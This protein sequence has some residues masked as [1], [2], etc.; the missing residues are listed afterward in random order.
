MSDDLQT[1]FAQLF[2]ASIFNG[3]NAKTNNES[4]GTPDLTREQTE[5]NVCRQNKN[6]ANVSF[7]PFPDSSS[8][9]II[10]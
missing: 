2:W 7:A 1:N 3:S 9:I 4:G 5:K 6:G 8:G 10:C